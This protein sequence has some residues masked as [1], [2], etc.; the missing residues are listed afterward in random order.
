MV[1]SLSSGCRSR[2]LYGRGPQLEAENK[3]REAY[4]E[5]WQLYRTY[6]DPDERVALVA[7]GRRIAESERE[8]G[9]RAER[10][11]HPREALE[12]YALAL[13]Y[14]PRWRELLEDYC[15]VEEAVDAWERELCRLQYI[16][17]TFGRRPATG[18]VDWSELEQLARMRSHP[19]RDADWDGQED[20]AA[21]RT[22]RA[23]MQPLETATLRRLLPLERRALVSLASR[24]GQLLSSCGER[25]HLF[26]EDFLDEL[27]EAR[28]TARSALRLIE[29]ALEGLDV[30]ERATLAERDGRLR[31][32]RAGYELAWS[33]HPALEDA[34][35]ARDRVDGGLASRP[36]ESADSA[37]A[38]TPGVRGSGAEVRVAGNVATSPNSEEPAASNAAPLG[39]ALR[40]AA[41]AIRC[42][43]AA[44]FGGRGPT[45]VSLR[46]FQP[47]MEAT[48]RMASAVPS[49]ST[50]QEL[51]D[52]SLVD[53][54][55]GST[56]EIVVESMELSFP[57][58]EK[59]LGAE[60]AQR[61][62][63]FDWG[64]NPQWPRARDQL[65][66]ARA[67][68]AAARTMRSGRGESV[69]RELFSLARWV[70]ESSRARSD[71]TPAETPFL[72]WE[73]V[74]V[75]VRRLV[76]EAVL[77]AIFRRGAA[78]GPDS[79]TVRLPVHD[80]VVPAD[81]GLG[82]VADPP[83]VPGLH[84]I[85]VRLTEELAAQL[86]KAQSGS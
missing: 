35:A 86:A 6:G 72:E 8:S 74:S 33:L 42:G 1:S 3:L 5:Y 26:P 56:G 14:A 13:E 24:W 17:A 44:A 19:G 71:R 21:Q 30:F 64:E 76:G 4:L 53:S 78:A 34:R 75:P 83:E 25:L 68:M 27:E 20:I 69:D 77:K 67:R 50:A 59:A 12:R 16:R 43:D 7:V 2:Q 32:A 9:R 57:L 18:R 70:L 11:R 73:R 37:V 66:R 15:R 28:A 22:L 60:E 51:L 62:C 58:V 29:S 84:E 54:V 61:I 55:G 38:V 81:P 31:E 40:F 45:Q 49:P 10:A 36:A 39:Q 80:R 48:F 65:R 46:L 85:L 63:R 47:A 41:T 52:A 23:A 79:L 82:V